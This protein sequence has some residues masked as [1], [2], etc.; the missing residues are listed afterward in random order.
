MR[1]VPTIEPVEAEAF[2]VDAAAKTAGLG[3]VLLYQ[4]IND[5]P[6]YRRGI[7]YLPSIKVGKRRLIRVAAL[8]EWLASL[9][10]KAA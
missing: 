10:K 9:E 7:P 2:S 3:R 4:A 1:K 8:R 6:E 5:D